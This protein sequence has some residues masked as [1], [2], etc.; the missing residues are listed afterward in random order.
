MRE[1][2][3][4]NKNILEKFKEKFLGKKKDLLD[5]YIKYYQSWDSRRQ[6]MEFEYKLKDKVKK[7]KNDLINK[8]GMLEIN[9]NYLDDSLNIN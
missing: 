5:R 6:S 7:L 4:K 1:N 8:K 3:K 2:T 9:I